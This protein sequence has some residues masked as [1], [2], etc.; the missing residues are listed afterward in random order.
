MITYLRARAIK[1]VEKS[2]PSMS[3]DFYAEH[4]IEVLNTGI[5]GRVSGITHKLLERNIRN[6][7]YFRKVLELGAGHGQHLQYVKHDYEVYYESDF[8]LENIPHRSDQD[9]NRAIFRIQA[10]AQEPSGFEDS[11]IDRVIATCLIVHL[12]KPE[13]ALGEWR[14]VASHGAVISIYVACEPGFVLR[15]I[16]YMTT[17]Q[18]SKKRGVNHLSVHYREHINFFPRLN[19]LINEVFEHDEV[20]R[21]FW[22]FYIPSWNL[23]LGVVYSIRINKDENVRAEGEV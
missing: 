12:E 4:Y 5:I 8:R 11:S 19:L 2:K 23:N 13:K 22:P 21:H 9:W 17:V 20:K 18:K 15:F 14:R 10:D 7:D 3:D 6:T 1:M 16:R